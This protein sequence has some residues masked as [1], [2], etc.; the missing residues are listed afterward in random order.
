MIVMKSKFRGKLRAGVLLLQDNIPVHT[1]QVAVTEAANCGFELIPHSPYS[2][3]LAPSDV[4]FSKLKLHLCSCHFRNNYEVLWVVEEFFFFEDQ[5]ATFFHDGNAILEHCKTKY[6]D[7]K[8]DYIENSS[9]L[10]RLR[11]FCMVLVSILYN[12]HS[13]NGYAT[14]PV[15]FCCFFYNILNLLIIILNIKKKIFEKSF[16]T[17]WCPKVK[18][19]WEQ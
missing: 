3:V 9:S 18:T 8:G 2:P 15:H 19:S 6:T 11:T 7:I 12:F 4:W 14:L 10:M 5:Y 16:F 17:W 13:I 1:A